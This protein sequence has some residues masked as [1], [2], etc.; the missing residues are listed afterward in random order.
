MILLFSTQH[1]RRLD[2]YPNKAP[3]DLQSIQVEL[4]FSISAHLKNG[5]VDS[6]KNCQ[7]PATFRI[8]FSYSLD[9]LGCSNFPKPLNYFKVLRFFFFS[10]FQYFLEISDF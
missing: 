2:F 10:I 3:C 5:S 4:F 1:A 8:L 9:F 7:F 6:V